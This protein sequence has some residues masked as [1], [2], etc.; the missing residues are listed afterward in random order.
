MEKKFVHLRIPELLCNS[1]SHTEKIVPAFTAVLLITALLF[2]R[3]GSAVHNAHHVMKHGLELCQAKQLQFGWNGFILRGAWMYSLS[4]LFFH[5][6]WYFLCTSG[7]I[8]C[9]RGKVK[10]SSKIFSKHPLGTIKTHVDITAAMDWPTN[11]S[12][13]FAPPPSRIKKQDSVE[14]ADKEL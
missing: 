13:G 12:F 2:C 3:L 8:G 10:G 9:C 7:D 5:H 1:F 14:F 6:I 11:A 4:F